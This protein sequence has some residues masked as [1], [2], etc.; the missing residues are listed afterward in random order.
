M[1][2]LNVDALTD[3]CRMHAINEEMPRN[4]W[5]EQKVVKK[6][7]AKLKRY[8]RHDCSTP[9][10]Q[11]SYSIL[12]SETLELLVAKTVVWK[13]SYRCYRVRKECSLYMNIQLYRI[14]L[15]ETSNSE[16]PLYLSAYQYG[17]NDHATRQKKS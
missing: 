3:E 6:N 1:L 9:D 14:L 15:E 5:E 8:S 11:R 16:V 17:M 7:R 12:S 13:F 10:V 4:S 2:I